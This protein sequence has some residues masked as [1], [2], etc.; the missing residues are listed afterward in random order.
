MVVSIE[1][2]LAALLDAIVVIDQVVLTSHV[3]SVITVVIP[4]MHVQCHRVF[5]IREVHSSLLDYRRCPNA[6]I[7]ISAMGEFFNDL[8]FHVGQA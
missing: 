1:L 4:E 2:L 3:V 6:F 7:L 8:A 5:A